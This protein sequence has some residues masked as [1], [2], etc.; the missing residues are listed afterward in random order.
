MELILEK[1]SK[2]NTEAK[3]IKAFGYAC[4]PRDTKVDVNKEL[5][6]AFINASLPYI[7]VEVVDSFVEPNNRKGFVNRWEWNTMMKRCQEEG[8]KLIVI[9]AIKMLS[10]YLL[11]AMDKAKQ[12]KQEYGIDIYFM[13]EDIY[14][15]AEDAKMKIEFHCV[16]QQ[17]IEALENKKKV[18]RNTFNETARRLGIGVFFGR[19][20]YPDR[21]GSL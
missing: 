17:Q 8:V 18:F 21:Q 2:D 14:T 9:P 20:V 16:L 19:M 6:S 5:M 4:F 3:P 13:L 1:P 10:Y 11:D 15:G 7:S 12:I